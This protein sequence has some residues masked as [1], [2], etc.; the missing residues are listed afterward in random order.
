M[1]SLKISFTVGIIKDVN[2]LKDCNY[3]IMKKLND[4]DI[5]PVI[6]LYQVSH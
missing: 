4:T 2:L 3:G 6:I 5:D 1:L